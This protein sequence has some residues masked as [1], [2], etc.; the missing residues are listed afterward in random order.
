MK[1]IQ[2]NQFGDTDVLEYVDLSVPSPLDDQVLIE[3]KAAGVSFVD[4]RQRKG[5]YQLPETQVGY[6][7]LPH[8]SGFQVVGVVK[9]VGPKGDRSLLEKRVV[10]M[11]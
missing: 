3:V 6:L 1:A 8:V 5:I 11:L 4:V 10:A 9:E 2:F 7:T